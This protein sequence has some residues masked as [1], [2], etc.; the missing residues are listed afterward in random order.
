MPQNALSL[1]EVLR[2]LLLGAAAGLA[3]GFVRWNHPERRRFGWCLA[4]ELPSA[5]LLGSA[6][7]ALGGF[8]A[9]NEYGRFL[10]AFVFGYLGQAALHD[11]AV[12]IIR[13]RT[14]LPPGG[15]TP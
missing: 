6:G 8:L 14:G 13:H 3:G 7:Y 12:A 1:L 2:D 10:F 11:L 9:F 4:W 15:G 5:A